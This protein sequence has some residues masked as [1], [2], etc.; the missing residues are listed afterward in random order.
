MRVDNPNRFMTGTV[1]KSKM[2]YL[3]VTTDKQFYIVKQVGARSW[4]AFNMDLSA[5][6]EH[7][8]SNRANVIHEVQEMLTVDYIMEY[9]VGDKVGFRKAVM[10]FMLAGSVGVNNF[11]VNLEKEY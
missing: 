11:E 4:D 2:V 8:H 1:A 10:E 3:V 5:N 7:I 6:V 9:N